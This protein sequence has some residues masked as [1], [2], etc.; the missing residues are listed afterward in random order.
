VHYLQDIGGTFAVV[1]TQLPFDGPV[2]G[3]HKIL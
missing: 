3:L 2:K 1:W